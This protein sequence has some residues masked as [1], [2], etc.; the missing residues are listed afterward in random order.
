MPIKQAAAHIVCKPWGRCDLSPWAETSGR[1]PIGEIWF[2]SADAPRQFD[3]KLLLKLIFTSEDLSI[4][5]H[6]DDDF[7]RL[8]GL[9]RGKTEAWYI[10][11]AEPGAQ[12][13]VGL[14]ERLTRQELRTA[15]LDGSIAS[16]VE[17]RSVVAGDFIFVPAGTIHAIGAGLVVAEIQQRSDTTFRLF[18]YGRDREIHVDQAVASAD[19]GPAK[20][21]EA[22]IYLTDSR[23]QLTSC[24]VFTLELVTI[25]ANS[26]WELKVNCES[27]VMV[28]SGGATFGALHTVVGEALFSQSGQT[29]IVVDSCGLRALVAYADAQPSRDLLS[30]LGSDTA[31]R[32]SLRLGE[33]FATKLADVR[34]LTTETRL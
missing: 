33:A 10:L 26:H 19:L 32:P 17:W 31:K 16:I 3:P 27:W 29:N 20:V 8:I 2:E 24:P 23:T 1:N 18:D 21:Q 25:P 5:V 12:V 14:K 4:Q 34:V 11:S 7:A 6:P 22:P 9:N 13:A 15:C 30:D 28:I